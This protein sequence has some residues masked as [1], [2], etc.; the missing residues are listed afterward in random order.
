[1]RSRGGILV[2]TSALLALASSRDQYHERAVRTFDKLQRAG[3]RLASHF[4]VLSE[5]HGLFVRRLGPPQAGRLVTELLADPLFEWV[6]VT[7]D[8][9]GRALT[10][11][12]ERFP[13]Q[14]FSLTDA[15]S[16]EVMR[17]KRL[18]SAFAFDD[19]FV[20]AGYS[21]VA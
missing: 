8:L 16:F 21:L 18:T 13:D 10:Q 15:T 19:H 12:I 4:L 20:T 1:M 2:D 9:V 7:G 14:R 3:T 6:D 17:E 11:W 5:L